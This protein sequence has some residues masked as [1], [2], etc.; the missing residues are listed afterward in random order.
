METGTKSMTA[1]VRMGQW[2]VIMGKRRESGQTVRTGCHENGVAEK[3][4]YCFLSSVSALIIVR[5]LLWHTG[6]ISHSSLLIEHSL[7]SRHLV[8]SSYHLGKRLLSRV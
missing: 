4:Y 7:H 5:V 2:A 8:Q 3:T 1:R 6:K